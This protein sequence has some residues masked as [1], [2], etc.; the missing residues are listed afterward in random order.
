MKCP[1][2]IFVVRCGEETG[3]GYMPDC[4]KEGCAW[5][6]KFTDECSIYML[7]LETNA[8]RAAIQD[9]KDKMPHEGQF[10]DR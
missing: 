3:T 4:L 9:I 1:M 7:A 5:W 8:L 2:R 6:N 10:R